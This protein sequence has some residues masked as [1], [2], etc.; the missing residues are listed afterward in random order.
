MGG[1]RKPYSGC[2]Q[3]DIGSS[4]QLA[5]TDMGR[6]S[7]EHVPPPPIRAHL[8][9][10]VQLLRDRAFHNKTT[11][12]ARN[13]A[14]AKRAGTSLSQVQ[15]IVKAKAGVSI[16]A[17]EAFAKALECRPQDLI[18]PYFAYQGVVQRSDEKPSSGA[19]PR[20]FPHRRAS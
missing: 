17:L 13:E 9:E 12:T 4:A 20:T 6:P 11:V 8:A 2:M 7:K 10:N 3:P 5:S 16:D 15:R 14:L 19:G 1:D 18:T